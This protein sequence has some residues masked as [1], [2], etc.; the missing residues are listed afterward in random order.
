MN[1]KV[2]VLIFI[3]MLSTIS[4][5]HGAAKLD[6]ND[7][8]ANRAYQD[9]VLAKYKNSSSYLNV[10]K[11]LISEYQKIESTNKPENV[12]LDYYL[13][14]LYE[15]VFEFPMYYTLYDSIGKRIVDTITYINYKD[16]ARFYSNKVLEKD[17]NNIRA[18]YLLTHGLY[19]EWIT[20]H[21]S[22]NTA[23]FI[24]VSN[25]NEFASILSY[26]V[27]NASKFNEL[28]KTP[29]K[30]ISQKIIE[31]SYFLID[32][33][34]LN[35]NFDKISFKDKVDLEAYVL[36]ESY[37]NVLDDKSKFYVLN[38]SSYFKNRESIR[39]IFNV[40]KAK[41]EEINKKEKEEEEIASNTITLDYNSTNDWKFEA[42]LRKLGEN[43]WSSCVNNPNAIKIVVNITD[44]CDDIYGK[45]SFYTSTLIVSHSE[46]AEYRK[47][48]DATSFNANCIS[49]GVKLFKGYKPCG[50]SQLLN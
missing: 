49:W 47:F 27:R 45:K 38:R 43:V 33:S 41:L 48:Q 2:L 40:A 12:N 37:C 46:I 10:L 24:G 50:R 15:N 13:S 23:P 32:V 28:D 20:F 16:S 5:K 34:V 44:G 9:K 17:P 8:E 26:I 30:E 29:E 31:Y 7:I 25:P 42:T 11:N 14:R 19:W 36:L 35:L 18:F 6:I 3:I 4:C 21:E 39:S 22:N 1:N